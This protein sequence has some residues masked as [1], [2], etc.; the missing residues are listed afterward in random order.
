MRLCRLFTTNGI[1][2]A[3]SMKGPVKKLYIMFRQHED[4]CCACDKKRWSLLIIVVT[5]VGVAVENLLVL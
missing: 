4:L 3:T 5:R 1:S 2:N